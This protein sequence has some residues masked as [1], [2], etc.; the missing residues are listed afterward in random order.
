MEQITY[1][2]PKELVV[3]SFLKNICAF[4]L[5][6]KIS[7]RLELNSLIKNTNFLFFPRSIS[8]QDF[9]EDEFPHLSSRKSLKFEINYFSLQ[10]LDI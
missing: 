10:K 1:L 7:P 3:V 2:Q 9:S 6:S 8:G 5:D 4:F